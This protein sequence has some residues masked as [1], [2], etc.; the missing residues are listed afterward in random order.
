MIS[1]W[2]SVIALTLSL[3]LIG[4][5]AVQAPQVQ[6]NAPKNAR[7]ARGTWTEERPLSSPRVEVAAAT[8]GRALHA[9]GGNRN[10]VTAEAT[11]E[12][13]DPSANAWRMLA[14]LQEARDHVAVAE[15]KGKLFAFGGFAT[16]VHKGASA[17]CFEYDPGADRWRRLPPMPTARAGWLL[18]RAQLTTSRLWTCCS[19][20]W[21]PLSQ[22]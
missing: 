22:M 7:P 17:D 9:V 18:P 2:M 21:S 14:P 6:E 3:T 12:A 10:G 16:P 1:S 4:G 20:M 11:H 19:Q 15:A 13:Y 8:V 5:A